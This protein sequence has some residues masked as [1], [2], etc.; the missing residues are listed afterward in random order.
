LKQ[1][2][3]KR[4]CFLCSE[5]ALFSFQLLYVL[6]FFKYKAWKSFIFEDSVNYEKVFRVCSIVAGFACIRNAKK[7]TLPSVSNHVKHFFSFASLL[8]KFF[9]SGLYSFYFFYESFWQWL[10]RLHWSISVELSWRGF[11]PPTLPTSRD[12]VPA[13]HP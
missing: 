13:G 8:R 11:A 4:I 7:L 5:S 3:I 12:Y 9:G 10:V 1:Q 2:T 6:H